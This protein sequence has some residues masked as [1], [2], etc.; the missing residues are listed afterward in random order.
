MAKTKLTRHYG[1][2]AELLS[3]EQISEAL[4]HLPEWQRDGAELRRTAKLGD[5]PKAVQVVNRVAEVAES[6][7]HHPDIDI[8][9]RNLTFHLSTHSDGGITANDTSMA[10]QID[11]IIADT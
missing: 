7:N 3:D 9:H 11:E 8:R 6:V 1:G 4:G 2:M 10:G 5:F